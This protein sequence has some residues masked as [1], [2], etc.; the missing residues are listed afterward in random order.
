M[1]ESRTRA[2]TIERGPKRPPAAVAQSSV[3]RRRTLVVGT[4]FAFGQEQLGRDTNVPA[5]RERRAHEPGQRTQRT[6]LVIRTD[7]QGVSCAAR[8]SE[9]TSPHNPEVQIMDR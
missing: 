6:A 4:G 9:A 1:Q 5:V 3:I 7:E 8:A 2:D